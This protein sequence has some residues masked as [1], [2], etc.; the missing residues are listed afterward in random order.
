MLLEQGTDWQLYGQTGWANAPDQGVGWWV[1][2]VQK[3]GQVYAFALNM[4]MPTL[5]DARQRVELG[6]ASLKVLGVL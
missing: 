2:W 6:K 3:G 1:G 5:A 4:E